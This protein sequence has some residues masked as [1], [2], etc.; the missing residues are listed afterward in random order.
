MQKGA[1]WGVLSVTSNTHPAWKLIVTNQA[2]VKQLNN[3][4]RSAKSHRS[5]NI[6]VS[7][8]V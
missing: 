3:F 7:G 2:Y 4:L 8:S 5:G 1:N 6:L